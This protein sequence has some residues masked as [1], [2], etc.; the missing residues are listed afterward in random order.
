M[1]LEQINSIAQTV[2]A[3]AVVG[4]LIYLAIQTRLTNEHGVGIKV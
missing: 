3:F 4:S 2:A 1:M